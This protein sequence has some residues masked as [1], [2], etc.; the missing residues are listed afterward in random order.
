MS[1]AFAKS[2][3]NVQVW[4]KKLSSLGVAQFPWDPAPQAPIIS[5]PTLPSNAA[6]PQQPSQ[7]PQ[8]PPLQQPQPPQQSIP[9]SS[10]VPSSNG[11]STVRI[12]TEPGY[13][14]HLPSLPHASTLQS[15]VANAQAAQQRAAA[16]IAQK[17]GAQGSPQIA[18]LQAGIA[19]PGQERPQGLQMPV[20][21]N[22]EQIRQQNIQQL[23]QAQRT[24]IENANFDGAGDISDASW[25]AVVAR[26]QADGIDQHVGRANA[27]RVIRQQ[28]EQLGQRL[29]G[30]GL[31]VPLEDY[32]HSFSAKKRKVVATSRPADPAEGHS[33]TTS[34]SSLPALRRAQYDGADESDE[35]DKAAIVKHD[36]DE[37]AIN[38]DLDDP[39]DNVGEEEEDDESA[40]QIMLCTYD[41]VQRVKNKWKCTLKDGVLTTNGKEFVL[42]PLLLRIVGA[43]KEVDMSF[44]KLK[45]NLNGSRPSAGHRC[46]LRSLNPVDGLEPQN[47]S[48]YLKPS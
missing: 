18:Q 26:R 21:Q 9:P 20:A 22:K 46:S 45:E 10:S 23:Q 13:E 48:D 44:T 11:S 4:Q 34:S 24:N 30:G 1:T 33:T 14:D 12:K 7:P 32:A 5:T 6:R 17:Y 31:L 8:L 27:D 39:N 40:G 37:D 42:V 47:P 2:L 16:L 29:E 38:S 19:L 35:D 41:K 3:F 15:G 25:D 36:S 28:V 43:D